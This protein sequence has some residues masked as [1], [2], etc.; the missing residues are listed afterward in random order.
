MWTCDR[1]R[2]QMEES[3]DSCWKCY[4]T[5]T[6]A[7]G[8][9]NPWKGPPAPRTQPERFR[10]YRSGATL[11]PFLLW[12]VLAAFG[13]YIAMSQAIHLRRDP[14]RWIYPLIFGGCV[15]L[16]PVA[17]T[18]HVLRSLLTHVTV[19]KEEGLILTGGRRI[20]WA[21]IE[22]V[23]YR[24]SPFLGNH[25]IKEGSREEVDSG[26]G[27][28]VLVPALI[29]YYVCLPVLFLLSPWH[30]RVVIRLTDGSRL[31]FRDL[32]DDHDFVSLIR[33]VRWESRSDRPADKR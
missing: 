14:N 1:C 28:P 33:M 10:T 30:P 9:G 18:A 24:S 25:P 26:L 6:A 2:E 17:F 21:A 16:G 20:P 4:A 15:L 8:K 12:T 7:P 3:L 22:S 29:F 32:E 5:R 13:A 23:E 19:S 31:V 27:L 11:W